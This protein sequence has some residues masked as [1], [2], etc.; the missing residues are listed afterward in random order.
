MEQTLVIYAYRNTLR[1]I[2]FGAWNSGEGVGDPDVE[3]WLDLFVV[4]VIG[5]G[6]AE[7]MISVCAS[8]RIDET[9]AKK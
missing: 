1:T 4:Q 6:G 2:Q 8:C 3:F 5:S 7:V 9:V